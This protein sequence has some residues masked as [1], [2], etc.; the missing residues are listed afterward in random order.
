MKI[1]AFGN[2][3]TIKSAI[4]YIICKIEFWII[5]FLLVRLIGITNPP[6]EIGH[7]L[8][9]VTGLMVAR[10]FL[11]VDSRI[12]YPKVD[13][14]SGGMGIIGME[15]P[16]MNYTH[17]VISKLFGYAHWYGRLLNL[18]IS[19]LGL[20]YFY[21]LLLH[22][23][24]RQKHAF[25]STIFL[26]VSIWFSFSRKMMP[27]TFSVS[28]MIIGL[29]YGAKYLDNA[30]LSNLLLFGLITSIGALAKI[31]ATIYFVALVPLLISRIYPLKNRVTL[32]VST[33]I[34]IALTFYWYF[35][36]NA[37]LVDKFG[38]EY[39]TGR[40]FIVGFYEII[41]NFDSTLKNFYFHSF[42]SYFIFCLFISG[43]II[44]ILK[45]E[46]KVIYFFLIFS[47][48]F[49]MYICK[50]GFYFYHHNYYI[51][52]FVPIMA[53]IAGYAT[54]HIKK[55]WAYSVILLIGVSEAIAN[56][57]HDL[58]IK[59]SE[60]YKMSLEG[61]MN[62]ISQKQDLVAINGNPQLLYLAHRKG[63]TFSNEQ[64]L[65]SSYLSQVIDKG[66]KYIII[67]K[68]N[69]KAPILAFDIVYQD[70]NFVVYK[71]NI[72]GQKL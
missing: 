34:P 60:M 41:Q 26:T 59:P 45:K 7:N 66:C 32:I 29:Y 18:I 20:L 5:F 27:D 31:P 70:T 38:A 16:I 9:Q 64:F 61:I 10:N 13:E 54:S 37:Y 52:P 24:F 15:F 43:I 44:L 69:I 36:W 49:S 48:A 53:L 47:L 30:K 12:F 8:R 3:I 19:S 65:D 58:F 23:G 46:K 2:I 62:Q 1:F 56:Q 50:S 67:D 4:Q 11:E 28:W 55:A 14:N 25:A 21:K 17:F 40:T 51:I 42:T 71:T 35:V 63:W 68:H 6:L 57:Q 33:L 39:N 72:M 22:L